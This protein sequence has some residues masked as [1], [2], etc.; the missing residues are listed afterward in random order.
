[1]TTSGAAVAAK[2]IAGAAGDDEDN[3]LRRELRESTDEHAV[4]GADAAPVV[5]QALDWN[6]AQLRNSPGSCSFVQ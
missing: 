6:S 3:H 4:R 2:T 1:M 5:A